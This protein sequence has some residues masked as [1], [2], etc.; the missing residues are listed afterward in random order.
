MWNICW[1][2]KYADS[3]EGREGYEGLPVSSPPLASPLLTWHDEGFG[4]EGGR[5]V[6]VGRSR[7]RV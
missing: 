3:Q 1:L 7:V 5:G 4:R 6:G 2:A